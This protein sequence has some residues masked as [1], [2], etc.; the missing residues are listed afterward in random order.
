M[1]LP[2]AWLWLRMLGATGAVDVPAGRSRP[3]ASRSTTGG[4]VALVSALIAGALACFGARLAA[5]ALTARTVAAGA[6]RA[7]SRPVP[8]VEGLAVAT[9]VWLCAVATL[10]WVRNPYAAGLLVPAVHLWLFAAARLART[11]RRSSR[12]SPAWSCPSWPSCTSAWRS[13]SARSSWSGGSTL[14]AMAGAGAGTTLLLAG[15]LAALIA[16]IRV[17]IARRRLGDAP[18]SGESI[19]TRGPLSYAGPGSLGGTECAL[20]R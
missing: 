15:L 1:P 19:R 6:Q 14:G 8:G 3:I 13:T 11:G 18:G 9:A 10:A 2:V 7:R 5:R 16:V 20:R 4:I 17:L 12:C